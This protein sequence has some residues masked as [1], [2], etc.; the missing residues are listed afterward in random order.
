MYKNH[1]FLT[2]GS[3]YETMIKIYFKNELVLLVFPRPSFRAVIF[4]DTQ[5]FLEATYFRLGLELV[6][7]FTR[8]L[9]L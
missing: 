7:D 9:T 5:S 4:S 8:N 3:C 2:K 1:C 6:L